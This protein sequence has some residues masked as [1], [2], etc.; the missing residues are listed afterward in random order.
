[1]PPQDICRLMAKTL[2]MPVSVLRY[3]NVYG[4][5]LADEHIA[6][7]RRDVLD[8]SGWGDR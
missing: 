2:S 7:P 3:F 4:P 8:G 1:M 5:I 6:G